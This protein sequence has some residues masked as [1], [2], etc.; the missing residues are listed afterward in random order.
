MPNIKRTFSLPEDIS[1]QLDKNVPNKERS[2]F[3]ALMLREALQERKRQA[4]LDVL[5][6]IQPQKIPVGKKGVVD[7][8]RDVRQS[9]FKELTGS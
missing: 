6:G 4:A 8:L 1:E 2:K 3:I 9:T 7:A 5:R